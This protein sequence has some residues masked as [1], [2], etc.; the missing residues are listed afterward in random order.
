MLTGVTASLAYEEPNTAH[1]QFD[2][3]GI[4]LDLSTADRLPVVLIGLATD[5][6]QVSDRQRAAALAVTMVL[7]P[8]SMAAQAANRDLATGATPDGMGLALSLAEAI[9]ELRQLAL[10]IHADA[11]TRDETQLGLYLMAVVMLLTPEGDAQLG[12]NPPL[13][14]QQGNT[15]WRKVLPSS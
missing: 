14:R 11:L 8:D 10:Q 5:Y 1:V 13:S 12:E 15:L 6:P 4:V 9:A 7:H 2:P 3:A